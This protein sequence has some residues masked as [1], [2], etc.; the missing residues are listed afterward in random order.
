M[1]HLNSLIDQHY[2]KSYPVF[3]EILRDEDDAEEIY[4]KT[5]QV[6]S[7]KYHSELLLLTKMKSYS[8]L[9]KR[10]FEKLLRLTWKVAF[11]LTLHRKNEKLLQSNQGF[12][13]MKTSNRWVFYMRHRMNLN[14]QEVALILEK[15]R[16]DI[17]HIL[18]SAR[19][20]MREYI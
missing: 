12:Y 14:I 13:S 10:S 11:D 5:F 15:D 20:E 6:L 7:L 16:A 2:L 19:K 4:L 1:K 9:Y 8:A 18:S 17:I 3:L